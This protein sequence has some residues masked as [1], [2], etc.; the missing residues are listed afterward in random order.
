[1][2]IVYAKETFAVLRECQEI[3]KLPYRCDVHDMAWRPIE[4]ELITFDQFNAYRAKCEKLL[5]RYIPRQGE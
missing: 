1:M 2:C 5:A 4:S 3:A